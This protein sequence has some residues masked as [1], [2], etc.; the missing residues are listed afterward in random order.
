MALA[1]RLHCIGD[2]GDELARIDQAESKIARAVQDPER[3][4]HGED[5]IAGGNLALAPQIEGPSEHRGRHQPER[6]VVQDPQALDIHQA[7]AV[8]GPLDL[9]QALEALPF[10]GACRKRLDHPNI[11]KHIDELAGDFGGPIGVQPVARCA[12]PAQPGKS[13]GGEQH[14]SAKRCDQMP[15][16]SR[17]HRQSGTEI[18]ANRSD[19]E[20]SDREHLLHGV[21]GPGDPVGQRAAQPIREIPAA[22]AAQMVEQVELRFGL[23]DQHGAVAQPAAATPKYAF[24]GDESDKDR[25]GPPHLRRMMRAF[26]QSVDDQLQAVLGNRGEVAAART[27]PMAAR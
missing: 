18:G 5:D 27:E 2:P 19:V 6:R 11:R 22:M 14:E 26:R 8:G 15:L 17:K 12:A 3:D 9:E 21:P 13:A 10:A 1:D 23:V 4:R 16:Y 20:Q 24:A 7:V 25:Q